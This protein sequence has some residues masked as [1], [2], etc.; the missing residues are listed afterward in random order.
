[1]R[2]GEGF[3]FVYSVTSRSSFEE[4]KSLYKQ[5]LMCK[6]AD[7]VPSILLGNKADLVDQREVADTEGFEFAKANGLAYLETSALARLNVEEAFY[8]VIREVREADPLNKPEVN[9]RKSKKKECTLL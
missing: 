3:I 7:S 6:D 2:S 9:K 4:A 8:Q 1:M 5:V